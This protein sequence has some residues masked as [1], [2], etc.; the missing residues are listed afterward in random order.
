V[1]GGL[2][3]QGGFDFNADD[4]IQVGSLHNK[5]ERSQTAHGEW[6]IPVWSSAQNLNGSVPTPYIYEDRVNVNEVAEA[7]GK[8]YALGKK[9]RKANGKK[10]REWAINNLAS[11]V[12]CDSMSEGID[13]AI[14]NY[15]PKQRFNLY[16]LS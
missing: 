14:K 16:K 13:T 9:K 6:V 7:I 3:D 1:T 2:Q 15:K 12:M 5:G 10:G 8:M 11:K 4:Y